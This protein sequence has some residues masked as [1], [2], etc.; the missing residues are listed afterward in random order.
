MASNF[1]DRSSSVATAVYII[2]DFQESQ[3]RWKPSPTTNAA[4][5]SQEADELRSQLS[6]ARKQTE[7]IDNAII[8]L[9]ARRRNLNAFI[10]TREKLV[11]G[12]RELPDE[13]LGEIFFHIAYPTYG[14]G[15]LGGRDS[16][17]LAILHTCRRF[18]DVAQRSPSFWRCVARR[19]LVDAEGEAPDSER[20]E[21]RS[22][23]LDE[24]LLRACKTLLTVGPVCS[25][26]IS[27]DAWSKLLARRDQWRS[28]DLGVDGAAFKQVVDAGPE[29]LPNLRTLRLTIQPKPRSW[30][31]TL[32]ELF[33]ADATAPFSAVTDLWLSAYMQR[34]PVALKATAPNLRYCYLYHV[35][36]ADV[37]H[38]LPLLLEDARVVLD[39]V[40]VPESTTPISVPTLA[41]R[42][43]HLAIAYSDFET[44]VQPILERIVAVPQLNSLAL[45][46]GRGSTNGQLKVLSDFLVRANRT[47]AHPLQLT[48]LRLDLNKY[49]KLISE[50]DNDPWGRKIFLGAPPNEFT[51][52]TY[53]AALQTLTWFRIEISPKWNHKEEVLP[54]FSLAAGE[55]WFPRLEH[56]ELHTEGRT[57]I[58]MYTLREFCLERN[59]VLKRVTLGCDA[60][61]WTP[62]EGEDE[63]HVQRMESHTWNDGFKVVVVYDDDGEME[64]YE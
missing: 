61:A 31:E 52:L 5:P 60:P 23:R 32:V 51:T 28:L 1:L 19:D 55:R 33:A 8:Q 4:L 29:S 41:L 49:P 56:L 11:S 34:I 63:E 48:S 50:V 42:V 53:C 43:Q 10:K 59:G 12:I 17:H 35:H 3:D 7:Q 46:F 40:Y 58:S 45:D 54:C 20:N 6:A 2:I 26:E 25:K 16:T 18:R 14:S 39:H 15:M 44:V 62:R 64:V 24:Q 36:F 38:V 30:A 22:A 13:I 47:F 27:P 57:R 21:R 37:L 9:Q